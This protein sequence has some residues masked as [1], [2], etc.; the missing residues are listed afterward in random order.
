M[1][2]AVAIAIIIVAISAITTGM[3][4][5]S[6]AISRR[7]QAGQALCCWRDEAPAIPRNLWSW[8]VSGT[9]IGD[10]PPQPVPASGYTDRSEGGG[11]LVIRPSFSP[12]QEGP[13]PQHARSRAAQTPVP[14]VEGSSDMRIPSSNAEIDREND[15]NV[16]PPRSSPSFDDEDP[17]PCTISESS[18]NQSHRLP[19]SDRENGL[20]L[21][22]AFPNQRAYLP[23]PMAT[24]RDERNRSRR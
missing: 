8:L 17:I 12:A 6:I 14:P 18:Q 2:V 22:W 10:P 5:L 24:N 13:L 19:R 21:K 1:I 4:S 15:P 23:Q 16:D 20:V 9:Y 3:H 11:R 7:V